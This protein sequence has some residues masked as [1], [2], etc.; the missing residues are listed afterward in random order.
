MFNLIT[1][2]KPVKEL[3]SGACPFLVMAGFC[4]Q[5]FE[6]VSFVCICVYRFFGFFLNLKLS[7]YSLWN[8]C[9]KTN[10]LFSI[11]V[12]EVWYTVVLFSFFFFDCLYK[13]N[14]TYHA[15]VC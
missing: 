8:Y 2:F 12:N 13:L 11:D 1:E 6:C 10:C 3:K 15:A 4:E 9:N 5:G 14:S 7:F